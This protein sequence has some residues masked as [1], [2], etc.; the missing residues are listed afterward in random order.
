MTTV[1]KYLAQILPFVF[2]LQCPTG[3]TNNKIVIIPSLD[4]LSRLDQVWLVSVQ[5]GCGFESSFGINIFF[6]S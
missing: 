3:K 4:K 5:V 2:A 6:T 1:G